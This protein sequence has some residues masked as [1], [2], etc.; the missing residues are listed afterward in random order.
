MSWEAL[1]GCLVWV[2]RSL[3]CLCTYSYLQIIS[4]AKDGG[5]V[6]NYSPRFSITGLTGTTDEIY[7]KQVQELGGSSS[8]PATVNDVVPKA[9]PVVAGFGVP[10]NEQ[11]GPTRYAPMQPVP[12]TKITAGNPTP[13]FPTSAF[14]IARA[15]LPPAQKVIT[16]LTEPQTYSVH[17]IE[18]TVRSVCGSLT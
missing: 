17:S 11:V 1:L 3:T 12:P 8:G 15:A 14:T 6:I 7:V 4:T 2:T 9:A 18:N 13:L 16:T 10:Y 5:T